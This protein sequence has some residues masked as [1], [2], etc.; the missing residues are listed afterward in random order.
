MKGWGGIP[1]ENPDAK[2]QERG[3][4][5]RLAIVIDDET[6]AVVPPETSAKPYVFQSTKNGRMTLRINDSDGDWTSNPAGSV[7]YKLGIR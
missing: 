3:D 7:I 1:S 6:V 2:E 4:E 5:C